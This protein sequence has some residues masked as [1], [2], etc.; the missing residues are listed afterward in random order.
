[1]SSQIKI[2]QTVDKNLKGSTL[3]D[4]FPGVGLVGNIVAN[5][6]INNLKLEQIG[7]ID[8]DKFPPISVVKEGEPHHPMRLYAGEQICNDGKCNQIV[9]CVS[10]FVPPASVT[11]ELVRCIL[12]WAESRGCNSVISAEGFAKANTE[13]NDDNL[14]YGITSTEGSRKWIKDAEVK[15]FE[16]GTIGGVTGVMLNEGCLRNLNVLGLLAEV[17]KD[18]PDARA[19]SKIIEAIDKLLLGIDLDPKPLLEEAAS[20]EK[21][22][23]K[24]SEQ[25][26]HDSNLSIPRYIG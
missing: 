4:G 1:M 6:L 25:V 18:I 14:V 23:Q 7:V 20:L 5:F 16:F 13:S 10:E 8:S 24:V 2:N 11:K 17:D 19:A 3:I 26:P 21:E 9:I 15:S 12:D 22:L